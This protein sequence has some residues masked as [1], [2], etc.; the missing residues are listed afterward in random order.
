MPRVCVPLRGRKTRSSRTQRLTICQAPTSRAPPFSHHLARRPPFGA[1]LAGRAS[2]GANH[3]A[4]LRRPS[5]GR[6]AN[7]STRPPAR[8]K[9]CPGQSSMARTSIWR[10]MTRPN[11]STDPGLQALCS[12]RGGRAPLHGGELRVRDGQR[13]AHVAKL[14]GDEPRLRGSWGGQ[15]HRREPAT[16]ANATLTER[17][18]GMPPR[19]LR[20][21]TCA[22]SSGTARLDQAA[23]AAPTSFGRS[24]ARG[25]F[26]SR[27]TG[28]GR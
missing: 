27:P 19:V 13:A 7:V 25:G 16:N 10:S 22:A 20:S 17:Q 8:R 21:R 18:P 15:A 12:G 2:S 6:T 5:R 23:C 3:R 28:R 4:H 24:A 14:D 1:N 9:T 26:S 11:C